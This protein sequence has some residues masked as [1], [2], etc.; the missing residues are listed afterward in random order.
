M[1]MRQLHADVA[2]GMVIHLAV[3]LKDEAER[4]FW[5]L[6][7]P[8]APAN[9]SHAMVEWGRQRVTHF[10]TTTGLIY[11]HLKSVIVNAHHNIIAPQVSRNLPRSGTLT[12][13]VRASFFR[14]ACAFR[15]YGHASSRH[16]LAHDY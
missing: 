15:S 3:F 11:L 13:T 5:K 16:V 1:A 2:I 9:Q 14:F 4:E 10:A 12:T 6:V 7:S 8:S